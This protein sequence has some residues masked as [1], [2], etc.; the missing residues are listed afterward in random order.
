MN[1]QMT[2][3]Q[4]VSIAAAKFVLGK[5]GLACC[6]GCVTG[7]YFVIRHSC[8][9]ILVTHTEAPPWDRGAWRRG[10]AGSTPP[11]QRERGSPGPA[12]SSAD[13]GRKFRA[14]CR[15]KAWRGK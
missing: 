13:R 14:G 11:D 5:P 2:N 8:F 10:R 4:T 6:A 15:T 1:E 12:R 3:D 9:V 7:H